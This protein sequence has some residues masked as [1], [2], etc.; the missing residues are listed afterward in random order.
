MVPIAIDRSL[1]R[2]FFPLH[3]RREDF[4]GIEIAPLAS[5]RASAGED[6]E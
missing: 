1:C 6:A 2:G 4:R 5:S 3:H